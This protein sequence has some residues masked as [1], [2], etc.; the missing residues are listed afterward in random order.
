MHIAKQLKAVV[1]TH[2]ATHII[3]KQCGMVL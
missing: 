2:A 1:T 3:F